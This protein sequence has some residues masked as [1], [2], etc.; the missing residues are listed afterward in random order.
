MKLTDRDLAI[1]APL[2]TNEAGENPSRDLDA[3]IA[4]MLVIAR[5]RG[6]FSL[7]SLLESGLRQAA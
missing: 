1:L 7:V 4:E 6:L 2:V 5:R 3:L